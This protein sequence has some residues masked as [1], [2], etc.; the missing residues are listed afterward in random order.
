MSDDSRDLEKIKMTYDYAKFHIGLY[1]SVIGASIAIGKIDIGIAGSDS[2]LKVF[3][4]LGV[5]LILAAG[6]CG[7]MV[8]VNT[9]DS[10]HKTYDEFKATKL[11]A[12]NFI[13]MRVQA[14][15]FWEHKFFWTG[16]VFILATT[17]QAFIFSKPR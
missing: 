10:L 15:L 11:T 2:R 17:L 13:C 8:A 4:I 9:P 12:M 16:L 7:A 14:W 1:A 5:A 3:A 6:A